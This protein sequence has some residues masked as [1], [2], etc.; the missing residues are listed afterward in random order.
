MLGRSQPARCRA[1][2]E[3]QNAL[4]RASP[5]TRARQHL[6]I[7]R[8]QSGDRRAFHTDLADEIGRSAPVE[9]TSASATG[10][11]RARQ[12]VLRMLRV[13]GSVLLAFRCNFSPSRCMPYGYLRELSIGH[14]RFFEAA[15]LPA[16]LPWLC[17]RVLKN[18]E[19]KVAFRI[20]V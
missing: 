3:Q 6:R 7:G 12:R 5:S 20:C 15:D 13:L 10:N 16:S 17:R 1:H 14:L 4:S 19:L 9:S 11:V 2:G 8:A 18:P